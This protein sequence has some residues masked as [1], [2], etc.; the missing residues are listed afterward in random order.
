M[1]NYTSFEEIDKDLKFLRLKSKID[2]EE[3]KLGFH[4]LKEEAA[5]TFSPI[6]LLSTAFGALLKKA[7]VLRLVE[8][9]VGKAFGIKL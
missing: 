3:L 8:K 1:K 6:N 9:T 5:E 7:V 4:S 2:K